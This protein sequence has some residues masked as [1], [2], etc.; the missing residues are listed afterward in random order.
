M[1]RAP[2]GRAR[3]RKRWPPSMRSSWVSTKD[4]AARRRWRAARPACAPPPLH[5]GARH[6]RDARG[7]AQRGG[8]RRNQRHR[9]QDRRLAL[10][11]E[12]DVL[13]AGAGL[14]VFHQPVRGLQAQHGGAGARTVVAVGDQPGL[15][16]Q[17][18]VQCLLQPANV[19]TAPPLFQR[20]HQQCFS[21]WAHEWWTLEFERLH[22]EKHPACLSVYSPD[23][24]ARMGVRGPALQGR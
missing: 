11:V 8:G 13:R 24:V 1:A 22:C 6:H 15:G 10:A 19:G 12:R 7:P 4:P 23:G 5:V 9:V 18:A 3:L 21:F 20:D 2:P 16:E 17:L 14:A